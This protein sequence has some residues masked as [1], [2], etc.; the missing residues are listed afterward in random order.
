MLLLITSD[1][2][3]SILVYILMHNFDTQLIPPVE[4]MNKLTLVTDKGKKLCNIKNLYQ[5]M[6]SRLELQ[7]LYRQGE[8]NMKIMCY[9]GLQL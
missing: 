6:L 4:A 5:K 3:W 8:K 9:D 7:A 2:V 1:R